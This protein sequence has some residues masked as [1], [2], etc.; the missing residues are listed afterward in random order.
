VKKS[1]G[2]YRAEGVTRVVVVGKRDGSGRE[3]GELPGVGAAREWVR[4]S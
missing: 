4:L 1:N 2:R 3:L